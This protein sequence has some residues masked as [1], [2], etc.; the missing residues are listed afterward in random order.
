VLWI[1]ASTSLVFSQEY[2]KDT[3]IAD[4]IEDEYR[5]D[6]AVNVNHV[7]VNVSDGIV[8]L[9]GIVNNL[10]AKE[11]AGKIAE[12]VKGVRAVSN[13]IE[14]V[15][16]V[17]LSDEGIRDR[18]IETLSKDPATDSYQVSVYVDYKVVTLSG[19]VDSYREKELCGNLAKSVKGVVHLEN[20]IT[21]DYRTERPDSELQKEISEALKWNVLVDDG[22]IHVRVDN[23][24]VR[25][26]GVVGSAAEKSNA[27]YTAQVAGVRSVDVSGLK[28]EWWAKDEDLRK[29]KYVIISDNEIEKAIKD[30]A[31]YDPRV[32]SFDITAE[33]HNG[34]VTLRGT[35]D[36]LKAKRA[37]GKL[38][39][40]TTG[41]A[42]VTNR[43]K[44]NWGE[45]NPS[46]VEIEQE[47][48]TALANN[49]ITESW[50][51]DVHLSNGTAT[52]QGVVDSYVEK[53]E[54][55]WVASGVEGVNDVFNILKVN[56]PYGYYWWDNYPY[57][58]LQMIPPYTRETVTKK[59]PN[60]DFIEQ[61][62]KHEI[63]WSSF[64][65]HEQV[66]VKV[67]NGEVVLEGTVDSW[68]EYQKAAENAW[69][70][71]AWT[72]TNKLIVAAADTT[73]N[74]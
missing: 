31:L 62:V 58:D 1:L 11:R 70:G 74:K 7:N 56:Y 33:S 29:N 23:G 72:V 3:E 71:G 10:K 54:A 46:D 45:E 73:K 9:T 5:F 26:I 34:W 40:H 12:I 24:H 68:K 18:V 59:I 66:D 64:V 44:V 50:E 39:E 27:E 63:W 43:I 25:L 52:L 13:R 30:A 21:V 53:T 47:I 14:V 55:E 57:Y 35:V 6:H 8:Q 61:S 4:A 41:V 20:K 16:P 48:L 51:I 19:T 60:D 2:L 65:D 32:H 36:N 37:A 42:G 38:A 17:V 69:E 49:A 15:P 28:V 22:M 67:N